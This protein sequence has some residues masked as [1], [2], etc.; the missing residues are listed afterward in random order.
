MGEYNALHNY[1]SSNSI[2]WLTTAPHTPQQ[3][4][5]SNCRHRHIIKTR[6]TLLSQASLPS[7]YWSYTFQITIY[8]INRKSIFVLQNKSPFECLFGR[9]PDYKK[10]YTF[11]VVSVI[12]G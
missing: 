10:K 9:L 2:S 5:I 6:L 7:S 1:L 8:L 3:N 12:H 4:C 11:L